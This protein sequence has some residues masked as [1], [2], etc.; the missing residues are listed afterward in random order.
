MEDINK[1]TIVEELKMNKNIRSQIGYSL[2]LKRQELN[3]I[4][5]NEI[6]RKYM[7]LKDRIK[8]L[9]EEDSRIKNKM[10]SLEQKI[11]DHR[12]LYLIS[13]PLYSKR[14][15]PCF[16]CIGCQK[17]ITGTLEDNQICINENYLEKQND[18]YTGTLEEYR[19]LRSE[20]LLMKN[21]NYKDE[22]IKEELI[23]NVDKKHTS[24]GPLIKLLKQE[25]KD[26][27]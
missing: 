14:Y 7:I 24:K 8:G 26:D 17:T 19:N 12:F 11:C 23:K 1:E 2:E 13:Y 27:N 5:N 6:V 21:D 15:M 25:K 16:Y 22:E 20:Y 3:N 10:I 18:R 9:E 4:K